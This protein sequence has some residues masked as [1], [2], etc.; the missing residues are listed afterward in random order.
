MIDFD[1]DV[2]KDGM[3]IIFDESDLPKIIS[4][5]ERA[6]NT[7]SPPDPELIKLLDDMKGVK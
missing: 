2:Y 1:R 3:G 5:F 7:W 4:I 6:L